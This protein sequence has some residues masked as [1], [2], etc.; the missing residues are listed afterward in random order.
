M[1]GRS[2]GNWLKCYILARYIGLKERLYIF[3]F[4]TSE[5]QKLTELTQYSACFGELKAG[6]SLLS[7]GSLF[8]KIIFSHPVVQCWFIFAHYAH[9]SAEKIAMVF[10]LLT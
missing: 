2:T 10:L 7:H 6:G 3:L 9:K 1:C 8:Q 4:F 5:T